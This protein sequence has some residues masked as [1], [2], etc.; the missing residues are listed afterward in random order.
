MT[1][2]VLLMSGFN[3]LSHG[4]GDL[5][6]TLLTKQYGYGADRSTVTNCVSNLG[7]ITGGMILG[8]YIHIHWT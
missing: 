7:S 5:Y 1:Y 2:C 8:H 3:F 6:P 4:S